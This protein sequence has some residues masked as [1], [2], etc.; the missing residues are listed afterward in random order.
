MARLNRARQDDSD[1]DFPDL[2]QLLDT[3]N[4]GVKTPSRQLRKERCDTGT[5]RATD[6]RS[7][8]NRIV[9]LYIIPSPSKSIAKASC[10]EEPVRK[11]RPLG[12]PNLTN[13]N[14][15]LLPRPSGSLSYDQSFDHGKSTAEITEAVRSSP[16]RAAK[17]PINYGEFVEPWTDLEVS[18]S[19]D[20][21]DTDLSG[22]IVSDSASGEENLPQ[23][24]SPKR[25]QH[26]LGVSDRRDRWNGEG[27][28]TGSTSR[29]Q[30][31]VTID[32][33]SPQKDRPGISQPTAHLPTSSPSK[34][35]DKALNHSDLK[36][37]LATLR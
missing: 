29:R 36:E 7:T 31:F 22:F 4:G 28:T 37:P 20:D 10:A 25:H 12:F 1:D 24:R 5:A 33:I 26:S 16:K 6:Q 32:L 23:T 8:P 11:Q 2:S 9:A 30:G 27:L 17:V 34:A 19:D 3:G 15:L 21:S 35:K 14:S 18:T 13:S